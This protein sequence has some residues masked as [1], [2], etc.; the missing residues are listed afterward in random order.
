MHKFNGKRSNNKNFVCP[1]L[2]LVIPSY[3]R[4]DVLDKVGDG[5]VILVRLHLLDY[6]S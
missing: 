5:V 4:K 3:G 6:L 1:I 2:G